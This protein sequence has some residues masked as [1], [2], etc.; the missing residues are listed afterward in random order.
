MAYRKF[1]VCALLLI[2]LAGLDGCARNAR[3][4]TGFAVEKRFD[5]ETPFEETW[6]IVKSVLRQK[7]Y[8]IY[9][10]DK[11]GVFVAYTQSR[12]FL[13]M[14]TMARR[15]AYTVELAPLD[16]GGTAVYIEGLRQ[17]YGTSLLTYPGWHDRKLKKEDGAVALMEAIQAMAAGE[18]IDTAGDAPAVEAVEATEA[19]APVAVEAE[20]GSEA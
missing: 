18:P 19:R 13:G 20:T 8:E 7:D 10:R 15:T 5:V 1:L 6:Q 14:L 4:T 3:D 16:G 2:A 17:V 9:T 12:E 11:R